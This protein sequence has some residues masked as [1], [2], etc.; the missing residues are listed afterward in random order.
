MKTRLQVF[1]ALVMAVVSLVPVQGY[2]LSGHRLGGQVP[3]YVNIDSA[4]GFMSAEQMIEAVQ[5][6]AQSWNDLGLSIALVYGG[7]SSVTALPTAETRN[8]RYD[9]FLTPVIP[10]NGLCCF[11]QNWKTSAGLI[12]E[13]DTQLGMAGTQRRYF[14]EDQACEGDGQ[15]VRTIMA[16]EFGHALGI[17]HS[18]DPA[19]TMYANIALCSRDAVSLD[20]DDIAA[21]VALYGGASAP[22]P[23]PTTPPSDSPQLTVRAYKTKGVK[24]ADLA[25]ENVPGVAVDIYR[26]ATTIRRGVLN[27]GAATDDLGTK[28]SGSVTYRVC[29]AATLR[30]ASARATW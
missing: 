5:K 15:Y 10:V 20:A 30:C 1:V 12:V 3:Y 19:A 14:A 25:W 28:G 16:H 27:N 26:D 17:G 4:A 24:R 8:S 18:A 7:P 29:E 21:A 2:V 23:T 13:S 22:E 9:V 6:A 11:T